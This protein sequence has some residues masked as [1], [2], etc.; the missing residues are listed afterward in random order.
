MEVERRR[1]VGKR[2]NQKII[3]IQDV[4]GDLIP[5]SDGEFLLGDPTGMNME[6]ILSPSDLRVRVW[7]SIPIPVS[8]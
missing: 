5:F 8:P 1:R 6:K 7:D 4:N 3:T 2:F